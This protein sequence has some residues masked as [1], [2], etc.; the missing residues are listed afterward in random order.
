MVTIIDLKNEIVSILEE[1]KITESYTFEVVDWDLSDCK[2]EEEIIKKIKSEYLSEE[3]LKEIEKIIFKKEFEMTIKEFL[4]KYR[5]EDLRM[6]VIKGD[7][8]EEVK[9]SYENR[10]G[11]NT[12]LKNIKYIINDYS[13]GVYYFVETMGSKEFF[14]FENIDTNFKSDIIIFK[15]K[16]EKRL[17]GTELIKI[18]ENKEKKIRSLTIKSKKETSI[19]EFDKEL[20]VIIT[21]KK[22]IN[23]YKNLDLMLRKII[24]NK[25]MGEN[26]TIPNWFVKKV[27]ALKK[28]DTINTSYL[29]RIR[30]V[31]DKLKASLDNEKANAHYQE[32][33]KISGVILEDCYFKIEEKNDDYLSKITK[34]IKTVYSEG[35]KE[36]KYDITYLEIEARTYDKAFSLGII[37]KEA[38]EIN[39]EL[40]IKEHKPVE[41]VTNEEKPIVTNYEKDK[42]KFTDLSIYLNVENYFE[43]TKTIF[44]MLL[45]ESLEKE[46]WALCKKIKV[47]NHYDQLELKLEGIR[48]DFKVEELYQLVK[49]YE[50]GV[51]IKINF[52]EGF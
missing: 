11:K 13:R 34:E 26:K 31:N 10:F 48:E 37:E 35:R 7:S 45:K 43:G 33:K 20:D 23:S 47:E 12:P 52:E 50:L 29:C 38:I 32:D 22:E 1:G 39:P 2:T 19:L 8:L 14:S 15:E 3:I 36:A 4:E 27:Y 46:T 21:T 42:K 24:G 30:V 6:F 16:I 28:E 49:K 40:K 5:N 9:V 18:I 44:L 51:N 17:T 25:T 41:L